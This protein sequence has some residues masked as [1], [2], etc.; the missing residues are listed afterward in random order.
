[1]GIWCNRFVLLEGLIMG[2]S[3]RNVVNGSAL[4]LA[5]GA[6]SCQLLPC[7]SLGIYKVKV[8]RLLMNS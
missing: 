7:F 3:G 2:V 1:M 4:G 6:P 5:L 8:T